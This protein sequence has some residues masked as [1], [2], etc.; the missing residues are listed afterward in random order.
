MKKIVTIILLSIMLISIFCI[1]IN[2]V[3]AYTGTITYDIATNTV[4]CTGG[5]ASTPITFQDIY[6][7]V[8]NDSL[9]SCIE[10]QFYFNCRVQI[11]DFGTATYF[12]DT[13]KQIEF[14]SG[15]ITTWE[16]W[17]FSVTNNA[18][19]TLGTV[20]NAANKVTTNGCSIRCND[21]YLPRFGSMYSSSIDTNFYSCRFSGTFETEC[22]INWNC[23]YGESARSEAIYLDCYNLIMVQGFAYQ[24]YNDEHI[25]RLTLIGCPMVAYIYSSRTY[26]VNITNAYA[27]GCT[28]AMRV[29]AIA[30]PTIVNF[31]D[32]DIN[33]WSFFWINS[34]D[35]IIN[36]QYSFDLHVLNGEI[37]EFVENANVTLTKN[38]VKI[39]S[40]LTNSTGQINTQTLTYGY[41]TE[42]TGDVIQDGSHPFVLTITHPDWA[43]YTSKFYVT[44][45]TNLIIS[46]QDIIIS[47]K[48]YTESD[49]TNIAILVCIILILIVMFIYIAI[50][51]KN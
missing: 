7:A 20:V 8:A 5:S 34:P 50:N 29:E 49:L 13:N 2:I 51:K 45:K 41:Y 11:G 44:E 22:R 3:S 24:V 16:Q 35:A 39:G 48:V 42:A 38:A 37:T 43:N 23:Y 10:N 33:T 17:V 26:P 25:N 40:W 28:Y 6:N 32:A 30:D 27:R 9:V 19:C 1:N 12:A 31:I 47:D 15:L 21:P 14:A 46:M 4:T 36:R 18:H